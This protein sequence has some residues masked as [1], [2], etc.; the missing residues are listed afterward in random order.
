MRCYKT[1]ITIRP[2]TDVIAWF[3]DQANRAGGGNYR[4]LVSEALR[5]HIQRHEAPLGDTLRRVIREALRKSA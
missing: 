5:D 4:S 1:R 2:D 3:R